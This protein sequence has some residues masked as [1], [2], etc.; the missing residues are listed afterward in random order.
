MKN[1]FMLRKRGA[2]SLFAYIEKEQQNKQKQGDFHYL[3][4]LI[5][6]NITLWQNIHAMETCTQNILILDTENG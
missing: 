6:T 3:I 5:R 2:Y 1:K 4:K